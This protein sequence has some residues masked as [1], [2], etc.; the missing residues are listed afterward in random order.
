[1]YQ[2]IL[3]PVDGSLTSQRGLDESFALAHALGST[4]HLLNVVEPGLLIDTTSM[5]VP[6]AHVLDELRAAGERLVF[7]AA[8]RA[9]HE[10]IRAHASVRCEPG[11]RI[12]DAIL[13]ACRQCGADLIVMG[14][15]GR[16]GI[17]RLALGSDAEDV[18][19]RSPVP[20]LVVR[21]PEAE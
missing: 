4:L 16:H 19:R 10:G 5:H 20:V 15:H 21:L 9:R 17:E 11:Q 1:M 12:A 18:L 7:D 3:V 6:P 2:R 8:A 14:T 13:T